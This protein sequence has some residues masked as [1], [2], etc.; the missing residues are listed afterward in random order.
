MPGDPLDYSRFD[1]V[2]AEGR[3]ERLAAGGADWQELTLPE[4]RAVLA[5]RERLER[6]A[7]ERR[8]EEDDGR[9]SAGSGRG[10]R[11]SPGR[12]AVGLPPTRPF[13]RPAWRPR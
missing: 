11:T 12:G 2:G 4:K 13:S 3:E 8:L 6:A 1:A 9:G 10:P 7:E 5:A